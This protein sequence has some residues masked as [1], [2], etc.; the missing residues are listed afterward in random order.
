MPAQTEQTLWEGVTSHFNHATS[1][2]NSTYKSGC[3]SWQSDLPVSLAITHKGEPIKHLPPLGNDGGDISLKGWDV[4]GCRLYRLIVRYCRVF[5]YHLDLPSLVLIALGW[6]FSQHGL[7]TWSLHALCQQTARQWQK[8]STVKLRRSPNVVSALGQPRRRWTSIDAALDPRIICPGICSLMRHCV[9]SARQ[10]KNSHMQHSRAIVNRMVHITS[11]IWIWNCFPNLQLRM[12]ENPVN[13]FFVNVK[14]YRMT[15][16]T[17]IAGQRLT[18]NIH[19]CR[20]ITQ[21]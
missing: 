1:H 14:A 15:F 5:F 10:N 9:F 13:F 7:D 4:W 8:D 12:D 3:V 18:I 21:Y 17:V 6:H 2:D 19:V 20:L 11:S 16:C